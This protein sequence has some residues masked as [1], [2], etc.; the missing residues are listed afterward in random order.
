MGI[1][2]QAD[3][4]RGDSFRDWM[5]LAESFAFWRRAVSGRRRAGGC[6]TSA[7]FPWW[8][9]YRPAPF[10]IFLLLYFRHSSSFPLTHPVSSTM[11]KYRL[12]LVRPRSTDA[13]SLTFTDQ[14]MRQE[15]KTNSHITVNFVKAIFTMLKYHMTHYFNVY[16]LKY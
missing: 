9:Y 16:T 12:L 13:H 4:S 5:D 6:D 3:A 8:C 1:K 14:L 10:C 11:L 15:N 7:R 2:F